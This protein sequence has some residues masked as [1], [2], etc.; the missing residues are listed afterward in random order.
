MNLE[1]RLKESLSRW[2]L[3]ESKFYLAWSRGDLPVEALRTYSREYGA[4]VAL[5]P[6]GWERHGDGA[7]AKVEREHV[8]LWQ[9]F[10]RALGTELN[11]PR[12]PQVQELV[13][14]ANRLFSEPASAIGGLYA[15]EGQQ[16]ATAASKLRGLRAH[17]KL[18]RSAEEYFEVHS[19]EDQEARL[20]LER[21]AG[22]SSH[23]QEVA[24]EACEEMSK[25]LRT[26]LDAL[27]DLQGECQAME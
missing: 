26:A 5:V 4:F 11:T 22:L 21:L 3:L 19:D 2:N 18:P 20:L 16:G 6:L 8:K 14:T 9:N 1:N 15:F 12:V 10:A 23:E 13:E 27:H 7:M 24:V 25:A 17:Y